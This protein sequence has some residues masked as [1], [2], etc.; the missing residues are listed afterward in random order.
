MSSPP[1]LLI[2]FVLLDSATGES[3]KGTTADK[4]S[5]AAMADE[6]DFRDAVKIK[7]API[8]T[9]ITSSQLIV[10]KNKAAW[11]VLEKQKKRQYVTYL[12]NILSK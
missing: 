10:Y 3:Y 5:I 6:A 4:V 1:S 12:H 2:W 7:N 11:M 8:L 9:G